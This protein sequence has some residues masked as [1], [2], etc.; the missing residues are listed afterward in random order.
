MHK[1]L[2]DFLR[3][4]SSSFHRKIDLNRELVHRP[5]STFFFKAGQ[6]LD[7]NP[8][9]NKDDVLIVDRSWNL[10][11]GNKVIFSSS[12]NLYLGELIKQYGRLFVKRAGKTFEVNNEIEIWG[13]VTYVIHK[14]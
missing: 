6:R 9:I 10:R 7:G 4:E 1:P 12:D 14:V 3:S 11:S 5:V 13:A 8:S 2:V